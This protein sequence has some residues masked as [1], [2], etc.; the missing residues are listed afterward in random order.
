MTNSIDAATQIIERTPVEL[1]W[2]EIMLMRK[3]DESPEGTQRS[4]LFPDQNTENLVKRGLV[5]I[6]DQ[7]GQERRNAAMKAKEGFIAQ[8]IKHATKDEYADARQ[9]LDEAEKQQKLSETFDIVYI[10]TSRGYMIIKN[11]DKQKFVF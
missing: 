9:M 5:T 7:F 3:L 11:L 2:E 8:A 4:D 1:S 6:V 10:L